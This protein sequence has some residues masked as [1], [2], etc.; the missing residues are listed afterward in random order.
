MMPSSRRKRVLTGR[1]RY[2]QHKLSSGD[3]LGLEIMLD[4]TIW[5]IDRYDVARDTVCVRCV[6]YPDAVVN[7]RLSLLWTFID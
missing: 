1:A 5:R 7:A 2:I 3:L 6:E 4:H